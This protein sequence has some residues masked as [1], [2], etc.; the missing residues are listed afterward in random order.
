MIRTTALSSALLMI[1][2]CL[3]CG[4]HC[5]YSVGVKETENNLLNGKQMTKGKE[6]NTGT[7]N[8]TDDSKWWRGGRI[9]HVTIFVKQTR[10]EFVCLCNTQQW[11]LIMS[12][13]CCIAYLLNYLLTYLLTPW[14]T[15][16][17]EKLT[18]SATSQE[19]PLIFGTQ[20]FITV[21]TSARHLSLS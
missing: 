18:G 17:L 15:V 10:R 2:D 4:L 7:G 20:R 9:P 8:E 19:I 1:S 3:N 6:E 14:S 11:C 21:P 13:V 5:T 16:L 12:Y